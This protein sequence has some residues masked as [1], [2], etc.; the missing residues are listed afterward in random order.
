MD[1][2]RSGVWILLGRFMLQL[3]NMWI[4]IAINYFTK[5]IDAISV[6]D[7][8]QQVIN[9]LEENILSIFGFPRKIVADNTQVFKSVE[10]V[11]FCSNYNIKLVY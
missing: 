5:W 6:R 1:N 7:A 9:F 8:N 10:L 2:F 11:N 4:L 3:K